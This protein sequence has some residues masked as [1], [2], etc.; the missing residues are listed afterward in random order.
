[1]RFIVSI[2][3]DTGLLCIIS[4][5]ML[6]GFDAFSVVGAEV[7]STA[8]WDV[9]VDVMVYYEGTADH[10][11]L[12]VGDALWWLGS[13]FIAHMGEWFRR[14][15]TEYRRFIL[16]RTARAILY[17]DVSRSRSRG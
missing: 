16:F 7:H 15:P 9:T 5:I 11:T 17:A 4:T 13:W 6:V 1:M 10:F 3:T 14:C 8:D 12:S 2:I